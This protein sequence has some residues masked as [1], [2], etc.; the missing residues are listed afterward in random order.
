MIN[1]PNPFNPETKISF[2]LPANIKN[3]IIEIFNIKGE[4]VKTLCAFPNGSLGTRSVIWDGTDNYHNQVSSG[5]YFCQLNVNGKIK[6][7]R[8]MLLLK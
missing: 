7:V 2:N 8:K 5:I 6:G 3:P 1:Q 4:K